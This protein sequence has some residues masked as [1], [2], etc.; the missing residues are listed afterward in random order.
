M[1]AHPNIQKIFSGTGLGRAAYHGHIE[2][3]RELLANGADP[4]LD[5]NNGGIPLVGAAEWGHIEVVE[6]LLAKG[7]NLNAKREDAWWTAT[8]LMAASYN[9]T[10]AGSQ[11][12]A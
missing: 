10:P 3:V 11:I 12:T 1:K 7:A 8:A 4:N 6:L 2:T 5:N 9:G